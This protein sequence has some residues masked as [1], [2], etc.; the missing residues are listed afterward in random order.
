MAEIHSRRRPDDMARQWQLLAER[1]R[2]HLLALYRSG[3]WRKYYS[4]DQMMAQMRDLVRAI[5][6]WGAF[7]DGKR[8]S[9]AEGATATQ[10]WSQ[11]PQ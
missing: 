11:K 4:E 8:P 10:P 9:D 2:E 3:R 1:R 5:N 7:G 6:E